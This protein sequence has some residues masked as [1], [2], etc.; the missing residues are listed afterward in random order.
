[1]GD[2]ATIITFCKIKGKTSSGNTE[3]MNEVRRHPRYQ[4]LTTLEAL[5]EMV[6]SLIEET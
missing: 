6:G 3:L 1:M 4:K 2:N 5:E